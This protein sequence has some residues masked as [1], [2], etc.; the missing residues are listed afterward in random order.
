MAVHGLMPLGRGVAGKLAGIEKL[1]KAGGLVGRSAT[2]NEP[3]CDILFAKV[4]GGHVELVAHEAQQGLVKLLVE[5]GV[6]VFAQEFAGL[7]EAL[8]RHLGGGPVLGPGY[9]GAALPQLAREEVHRCSQ[10]AQQRCNGPEEPGTCKEVSGTGKCGLLGGDEAYVASQV[11]Y[12]FAVRID[13]QLS[14]A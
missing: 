10:Q 1:R 8:A 11:A 14:A 9:V 12:V 6:E 7:R 5:C 4:G 2:F 3:L 13:H